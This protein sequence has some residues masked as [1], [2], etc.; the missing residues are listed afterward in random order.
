MGRKVSIILSEEQKQQIIEAYTIKG[1]T[2]SQICNIG[3]FPGNRT[4]LSKRLKEWNI[5]IKNRET[6]LKD[7]LEE[8]IKLWESGVS[9]CALQK[10]FKI[11]KKTISNKLRELGYDVI[12][13]QLELQFNEH[14]FDSIDTEEKAYWLGFIF[15]DGNIR[16]VK[17]FDKKSEYGFQI[18]LK[19]SDS[20]HL[21]KFNQFMRHKKDNRHY[22]N[23]KSPTCSWYVTNQHLWETLNSYGCTPN[24]SLT[25]KFPDKNIFKNESLIRHFIRGYFDGDGCFSQDKIKFGFTPRLSLLGTKEFVIKLNNI[26]GYNGTVTQKFGKH[27]YYQLRFNTNSSLLF[28]EYLY[29]DCSVY[30]D[31]KY[32]KYQL[33]KQYPVLPYS[34]YQNNIQIFETYT[35]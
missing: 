20:E 16:T 27:T 11:N 6:R 23:T 29:N 9:L 7:N 13:P 8:I 18:T 28:M 10:Q 15:A 3:L 34:I 26:C 1:L 31:R 30:L 2:V 14:I 4:T 17:N 33:F 12:N 19:K 24:K 32:L 5:T 25:L 35:K 21:L 22:H